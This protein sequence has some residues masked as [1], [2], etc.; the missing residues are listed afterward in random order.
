MSPIPKIFDDEDE[1]FER[2]F[3]DE[4]QEIWSSKSKK[5]KKLESTLY[6]QPYEE[7]VNTSESVYIP[8][9]SYSRTDEESTQIS[10]HSDSKN[11]ESFPDPPETILS[12]NHEDYLEK[13]SN[14]VEAL[15]NVSAMNELDQVVDGLIESSESSSHKDFQL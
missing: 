9:V 8:R 15:S 10:I 12:V 14:H 5:R 4:Q 1:D 11:V 7:V 6:H 3:K 13:N 2:S